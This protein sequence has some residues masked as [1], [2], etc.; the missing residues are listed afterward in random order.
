MIAQCFRVLEVV[1]GWGM[2]EPVEF[3]V[4]HELVWPV[5]F[6]FFELDEL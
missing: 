5:D 3:A 4:G 6:F 1:D 2:V